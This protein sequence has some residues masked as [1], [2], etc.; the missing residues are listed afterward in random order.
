MWELKDSWNLQF[1]T[2]LTSSTN[3]DYHTYK[4]TNQPFSSFQHVNC[5]LWII[6]AD[7]GDPISYFSSFCLVAFVLS[8]T[9]LNKQLLLAPTGALIVMMVYYIS[10]GNFFRF[11]AFM[12]FYTVTSV[13]LSHLNSINAIG[14]ILEM[15]WGYLGNILGISRGYL[16]DILRIS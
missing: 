5:K 4:R 10:G 12:P 6:G 2:W 1:L 15:S 3:S 9:T 11:W 7:R 13:T 14:D 16:G 8:L